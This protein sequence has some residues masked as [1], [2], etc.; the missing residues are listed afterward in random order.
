MSGWEPERLVSLK[1]LFQSYTRIS[2]VN[3]WANLKYFF[4]QVIPVAEANDIKI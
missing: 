2:E 3:L 4:E 1:Q